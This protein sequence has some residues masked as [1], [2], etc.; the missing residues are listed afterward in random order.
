MLIGL[1][2]LLD[3]YLIMCPVCTLT[4]VAGLGISRI[5]G[6]DDLITSIWIGGFLLSF[7]FITVDWIDKKWPKSELNR[8]T[9]PI[10]AFFYVIT[11]LFLKWDGAIGITKNTLWGVDKII[12]GITTGT[13]FFLFGVWADK[14]QRKIYKK[15]FFNFQKVVFPVLSLIIASIIFSLIIK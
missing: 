13:I 2:A 12:L 14:K 9:L 15:Q 3:Y 7:S 10:T 11:I 1:L 4:V 6:I 5:L 8:F